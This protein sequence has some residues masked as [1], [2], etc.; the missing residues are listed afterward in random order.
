MIYTQKQFIKFIS[1]PNAILGVLTMVLF[2]TTSLPVAAAVADN[3]TSTH[4][5]QLINIER[6]KNKLPLLGIDPT[7]QRA[8]QNKAHDMVLRKYFSH[9]DPN[10][11]APWRWVTGADY[12]YS[13]AGE[14]LAIGFVSASKQHMS[15]MQSPLHQRNILNPNYRDTGIAVVRGTLR[16]TEEWLIVQFFATPA[17][18]PPIHTAPRTTNNLSI[19]PQSVPTS[20]PTIIIAGEPLPIHTIILWLF[21]IS[22]TIIAL[23]VAWQSI[24]P[25]YI[26]N[27]I[28]PKQF[29]KNT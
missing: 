16:D 25:Q 9:K 10:G 12:K 22:E 28:I 24:R 19:P 27:I 2:F 3:I 4:I 6:A 14:N 18:I 29:H 8:A 17:I 11:Q 26:H 20:L 15:W 5:L 7:L 23:T 1:I 13:Y 21:I